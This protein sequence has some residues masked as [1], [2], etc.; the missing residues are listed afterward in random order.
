MSKPETIVNG[1]FLERR[2]TGV[3]RYAGEILSRL[4]GSV[5]I[6]R[7]RRAAGGLAGHLWEQLS[8]PAQLPAGS[9]LWSP[10]NTGPLAVASQVLTLQ[11]LAPLEHPEWFQPAFSWWYRFFLPILACKVRRIITSSEYMRRKV[12]RRFSIPDQQVIVVPGGVD[13]QR[14]HPNAARRPS[15]TG[16]QPYILFV[17]SLE[18]RK[19]LT[20][21]LEAWAEIGP[22]FPGFS[23]A[24]AG[25]GGP[26]ASSRVFRPVSFPGGLERVHYLGYVPDAVLPTLYA[27]AALFVFPSL[28]EGFGL[29]V[30]EAMASGAPVVAS[31]AGALPEVTAGAALLFDPSH[32]ALL[33]AALVKCLRSREL[34]GWL[35]EKGLERSGQFSWDASAAR[36]WEILGEAS[37]A[38][39][40]QPALIRSRATGAH[41]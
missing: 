27:G 30:L 34:R 40:S 31:A 21:L 2:I 16:E 5:R 41:R 25:A 19:N 15:M 7:P 8:L 18:P 32:P 24:I 10:A 28:E 11:D 26:H 37:G 35:C 3:E 38:L 36:M 22:R 12:M 29:P 14:F 23:L 6:V 9:V 4:P 39:A 33:S 13:P 20:M 17:G 1:R